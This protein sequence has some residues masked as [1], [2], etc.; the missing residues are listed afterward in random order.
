MKYYRGAVIIAMLVVTGWL[1][2][3]IYLSEFPTQSE[4]RKEAATVWIGSTQYWVPTQY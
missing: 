1:C 4:P 3:V 2:S